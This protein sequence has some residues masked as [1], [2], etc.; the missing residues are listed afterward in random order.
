METMSV[1]S[2]WKHFLAGVGP[3]IAGVPF[4]WVG[5]LEGVAVLLAWVPK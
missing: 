5:P 1:T 4:G 2:G 3:S